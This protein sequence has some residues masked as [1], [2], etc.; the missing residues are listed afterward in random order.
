MSYL[1]RSIKFLMRYYM[2][3]IPLFIITAIPALSGGLGS[4]TLIGSLGTMF[5]TINDP[6]ML[7]QDP[8]GL[9]TALMSSFALMAGG[10]F[11]AFVLNF[12]A[13]PATYGMI[14]KALDTNHADLNDF[15]PSLQ[16]NIV[17]YVLYWVG[18]IAVGLVCGLAGIIL[19]VLLGLL[20]A[21]LKWFGIFIAVIA[22]LAAVAVGIAIGVLLSLWFAAMVI[23]DLDVVSALK[24]SVETAKSSFWTLLG[25]G[26][27]VALASSIIS[28]ILSFIGI[29]PVLGPVILSV[30]PTAA[31]FLMTVFYILV[32]RD[33][34]GRSYIGA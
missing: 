28:G 25:I 27:L 33:K 12:A 26:L 20:I 30:I 34:S 13:I 7:M 21:A 32:Y 18:T 31:S 29:I 14:N 8:G 22:G 17:K 19:I 16:Q 24:K 11:L 23:D 6:Y 9:I 1:E 5:K 2:L 15:V 3:A 10:G 4:L